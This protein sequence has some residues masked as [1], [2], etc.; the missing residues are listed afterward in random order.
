MNTIFRFQFPANMLIG[1]TVWSS[2][3]NGLACASCKYWVPSNP[4]SVYD[5]ADQESYQEIT[6]GRCGNLRV[7]AAYGEKTPHARSYFYCNKYKAKEM[8]E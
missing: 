8:E 5:P 1:R 3:Q 4:D 2:S 7:L 6:T